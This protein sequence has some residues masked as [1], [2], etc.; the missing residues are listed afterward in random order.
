MP[1]GK[2]AAGYTYIGL[3]LLLLLMT[4]GLGL[5]GESYRITRQR[6]QEEELLFAGR[7]LKDA[8]LRYYNASP[9][10]PKQ[11]PKRLDDLLNDRRFPTLRRHLARIPLDPFSHTRDWG[12][13]RTPDEQITGIYTL[14]SGTPMKTANF[15]A[16][17]D[18]FKDAPNYQQWIFAPNVGSASAATAAPA[19]P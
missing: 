5:A 12:L 10:E 2:S 13:Q 18:A 16:D 14:H 9:G 4:L 11:F 15:R 1:R 3:L 17:E 8:L 7:A 19:Q 6:Q